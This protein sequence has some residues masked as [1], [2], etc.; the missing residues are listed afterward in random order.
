MW[1]IFNL[2]VEKIHTVVLMAHRLHMM[3]GSLFK[4]VPSSAM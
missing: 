1:F 3:V 4:G 2:L